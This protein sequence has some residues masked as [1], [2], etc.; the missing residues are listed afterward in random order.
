MLVW[1]LFLLVAVTHCS[2]PLFCS[3]YNTFSDIVFVLSI[4]QARP[5]NECTETRVCFVQ[6]P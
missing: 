6:D 5:G 3:V 2:R 4:K 1:F